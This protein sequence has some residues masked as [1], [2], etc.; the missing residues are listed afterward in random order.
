MGKFCVTYSLT[1]L[2]GDLEVYKDMLGFFS[3]GAKDFCG[4]AYNEI[5]YL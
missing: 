4:V 1:Y 3:S 2:S 5:S